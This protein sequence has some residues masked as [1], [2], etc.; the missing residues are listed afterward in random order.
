[1]SYN[2]NYTPDSAETD[3]SLCLIRE[4]TRKH[5][6]VL[7]YFQFLTIRITGEP[8]LRSNLF[9]SLSNMKAKTRYSFALGL[10]TIVLVIGFQQCSRVP[11]EMKKDTA[12]A[13]SSANPFV[14]GPPTDFSVIHR[15]VLYIDMSNS[16]ISASCPQ[17]V[18]ANINF[19]V[20]PT[21][22]VYDPNK[23]A[24]NPND[25]RADAS[26]CRVNPSLADTWQSTT[27]ANPNINAVPAQFYET[28]KGVDP[29]A[30]RLVI[31]KT[32]ITQL[33]QTADSSTLNSAKI[34]IVPISGGV[35]QTKLFN[36][37]ASDA[38]VTNPISFISV[39]DPKVLKILDVL[40]SEHNRN[41][42]AVQSN[43]EFRFSQTTMGTSSPGAL[44]RLTYDAMFQDMSNLHTKGLSTQAE[45]N[46]IHIG[47]GVVTPTEDQFQKVLN[48]TSLC[49][50]CS[51]SRQTCA[52]T[53]SKIVTDM[54]TAWGKPKDNDIDFMDFNLGLMQAMP[55][56]FGTGVFKTDFVQLRKDTMQALW[57]TEITFFDGLKAKSEAKNRKVNIWQS[58]SSD[59]PFKLPGVEKSS[60]SY[61]LTDLYVLNTNV[62][63]NSA[64]KLDIDSDGDGLFDSEEIAMGFEP[65]KSRTNGYC[66][67]GFMKNPAFRER[68]EAMAQA[69][70]CDPTLDS[71]GDSL[72]ECEESLLGTDPFDFDTDGDGVPDYLEWLYG[73]NPL[74]S[75]YQKDSNGDGYPNLVNFS[76]GLHPNTPLA[77][78][79]PI[80]YVNYALNSIGKTQVNDPIK[81][82]VWVEMFQL[83]VKHVPTL[84]GLVGSSNNQSP[85]YPS[86]DTAMTT[87]V[88]RQPIQARDQL[89]NVLNN[90]TAN[91]I[92]VL[93][94]VI[95]RDDPSRAFWRLYKADVFV[96]QEISQPQID[97]SNLRQIRVMD[98]NE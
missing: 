14:L 7:I 26:D 81:G 89:I 53:C 50:T 30:N 59:V 67:D 48:F 34:M 13:S 56:Y 4:N 55:I 60:I 47:D 20:N 25:H 82:N 42:T 18:N 44:F 19:T 76:A 95:D 54:E 33:L 62:R 24:G 3:E 66:L 40:L 87:T 69:K 97:L 83:L 39:T 74:V 21:Y 77:T 70:S 28:P 11:L 8:T 27:T 15:Y 1:M 43:D 68:C 75:D 63:F 10:L 16:M 32:W 98:R 35:S 2:E 37:L 71:D 91:Q 58:N 51:A 85:L 49:Q 9:L 31:A 78:I 46:F 86:R 93:A 22:T 45:Y 41:Y 72:N 96:Q 6:K 64:G 52:G 17:D 61:K 84:Q 5:P 38:G 79:D 88:A 90:K 12:F 29:N 94:R 36:K 57:P 23:G 73:F 80:N 65:T 92:T